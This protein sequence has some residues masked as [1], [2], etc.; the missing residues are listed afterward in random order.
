M[1]FSIFIFFVFLE[2]PLSLGRIYTE[3]AKSCRNFTKTP[4]KQSNTQP[5]DT[6]GCPIVTVGCLM[7]PIGC[8][9]VPLGVP[10]FQ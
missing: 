6:V 4:A 10:L 2:H 8:P 3:A 7:V 5:T 1:F 9:I